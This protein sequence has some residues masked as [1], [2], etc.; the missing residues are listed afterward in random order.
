MA[1]VAGTATV[2]IDG[3]PYRLRGNL[4]VSFNDVTRE[5]VFGLDT[6]HGY[7]ET[8]QAAYVEGDFTDDPSIDF[9]KFQEMTNATVDVELD[10]G[11]KGVLNNAWCATAPVLNVDEGR[12]TLRFEGISGTWITQQQTVAERAS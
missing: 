11:K 3:V 12:F 1:K 10:N 8:R 6:F 2:R 4:N 9:K 7:K 5:P